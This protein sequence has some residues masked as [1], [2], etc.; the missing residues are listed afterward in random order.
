[1]LAVVVGTE[2]QLV[3]AREHDA[4][5]CLRA[6]SVAQIGGVERLCRGHR[7]GHVASLAWC[8]PAARA[9]GRDPL[10]SIT[11]S[12]HIHGL[13]TSR[14]WVTSAVGEQPTL[15]FRARSGT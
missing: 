12:Q 13:R 3:V 7:S 6:A 11:A 15:L 14:R 4:Y 10:A 9:A 2:Q 1:M 8:G 5:I